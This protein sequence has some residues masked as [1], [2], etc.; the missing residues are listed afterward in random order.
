MRHRL[1][2]TLLSLGVL[3]SAFTSAR[4]ASNTFRTIDV[5]FPCAQHTAASGINNWGQIVGGYSDSSGQLQGFL[6]DKGLITTI[7]DT[8]PQ[9]I[10]NRR[11]ITGFY[12]D[13]QG[14]HGFLYDKSGFT[15]LDVPGAILTQALGINGRTQIVGDY[16][17]QQG[18]HH[19][20]LLTNG[21]YSTVD[22]P[23][24]PTDSSATGI[25]N[26]GVIVGR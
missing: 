7:P 16:R 2:S 1:I 17:D 3:L 5:P 19:S 12:S 11:Q 13:P 15:T 24:S 18:Q 21:V 25:N 22:P 26:A 10:N 14:V 8:G 9:S 6:D 20:F 23:F 4:A